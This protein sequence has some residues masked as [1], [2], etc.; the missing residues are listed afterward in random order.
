MLIRFAA[1]EPRILA[2]RGRGLLQ[3]GAAAGYGNEATDIA[4]ILPVLFIRSALAVA[5]VKSQLANE[6]GPRSITGTTIIRP[7]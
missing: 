3:S 6:Y 1:I 2:R 5:I 4:P 7:R